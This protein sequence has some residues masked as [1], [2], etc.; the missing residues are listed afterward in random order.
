MTRT[1]TEQY[2]MI[3][4]LRQPLVVLSGLY[5]F[6]V[7]I[8]F[9]APRMAYCSIINLFW[10]LMSKLSTTF[11]SVSYGPCSRTGVTCVAS[12]FGGII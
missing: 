3:H 2:F 8:L 1:S 7:K 9:M 11:Q 6:I 5:M 12:D 4:D 10:S